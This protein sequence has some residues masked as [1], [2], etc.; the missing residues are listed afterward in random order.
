[1]YARTS[2][3]EIRN[4][5]G[6]WPKSL[7]MVV[8]LLTL[9]LLAYLDFVTSRFIQLSLFYAL[10]SGFV[11]WMLGRRAVLLIVVLATG[12]TLA[13]DRMSDPSVPLGFDLA[14]HGFRALLWTILGFAMVALRSRMDLL[15]DA[16]ELIRQDLEAGRKVQ[17]AFLSRP[18]PDDPRIDVAVAFRTARELGGDYFDIRIIQDQLQILVADVSGK[19]ASAA[20]VTALLCC[21]FSELSRRH[22]DPAK[23]LR[24]LD[25]EVT[26]S[27]PNGMFI[28]A[29]YMTMDLESGDCSYASA[30]HDPQYRLLS[31]EIEQLMPTG[32]PLGLLEGFE[33]DVST[34]RMAVG[35]SVVLFTDGIVNVKM[36]DG[37]MGEEPFVQFL[38]QETADTSR[39]LTER[40]FVFLD[41]QGHLDDDAVALV[42]RRSPRSA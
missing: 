8:L 9:I 15:D 42:L 17:T 35:E 11:G 21:L 18:V 7:L 27:L 12:L 32:L 39:I 5:I 41:G 22:Q 28:T 24:I 25:K 6:K 36:A 40:I 14:N 10:I 13:S 34:F 1:M 29:F 20:L 38:A 26:P 4:R 3:R 33:L 19:G 30:G 23:V 16:Y 31:G 37:R 2:V